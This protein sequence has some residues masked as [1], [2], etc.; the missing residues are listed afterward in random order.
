M[1]FTSQQQ[2]GTRN[3]RNISPNFPCT[4]EETVVQCEGSFPATRSLS[5]NF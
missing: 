2:D 3:L 4:E 1:D 5:T